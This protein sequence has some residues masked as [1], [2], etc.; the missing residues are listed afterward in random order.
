M[1]SPLLFSIVLEVQA[2][3]I[4]L[5]KEIEGI[6]IGKEEIK[7][8]LFTDYISLMIIYVENPKEWTR[9]C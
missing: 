8:S 4:R 6:Q 1:P 5:E 7:L 2:N 9:N 3:A